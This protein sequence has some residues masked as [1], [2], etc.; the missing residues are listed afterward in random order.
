MKSVLRPLGLAAIATIG[1]ATHAE[2]AGSWALTSEGPRG[3]NRSVLTIEQTEDGYRGHSRGA[4]GL[5]R[6]SR[7]RRRRRWLL[8]R[9]D[10]A[11]THWETSISATP[12]PSAGTPSPGPL[13]RRW[14][15]GRLPG[16][17]RSRPPPAS[18][19]SSPGQRQGRSDG[20]V[21]VRR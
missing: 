14:A 19:A 17:E 6:A 15:S 18:H 21:D 2:V 11:D 12:A 4:T 8:L 10:D 9:T 1:I 3:T 20:A 7:D 5:A 13:Q 16:R